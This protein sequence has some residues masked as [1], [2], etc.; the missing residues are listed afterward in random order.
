MAYHHAVERRRRAREGEE[1]RLSPALSFVVI[2]MMA[3][4]LWAGI[5]AIAELV[6]GL[7]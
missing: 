6:W 1:A 3:V 2:G 5:V 7:L 4:L